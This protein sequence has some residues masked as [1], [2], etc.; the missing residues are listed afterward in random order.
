MAASAPPGPPHPLE[1]PAET[2]ARPALPADRLD[3]RHDLPDHGRRA[4]VDVARDGDRRADA[5][6]DRSE[7]GLAHG[8][9]YPDAGRIEGRI[10]E[11]EAFQPGA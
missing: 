8:E 9:D 10:I 7:M 6:L 5:R 2:L 11:L 3:A 1:L 4:V